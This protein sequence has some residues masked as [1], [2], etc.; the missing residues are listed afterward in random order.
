MQNSRILLPLRRIGRPSVVRYLVLAAGIAAMTALTIPGSRT[1]ATLAQTVLWGCLGVFAF[2]WARRAMAAPTTGR[3]IAYLTS[4]RGV[5]D[6]L[7]VLPAPLALACGVSPDVAW[8]FAA[9]WL[10]KLTPGAPGLGQLG[11]VLSQEARPLASV[12]ILFVIVLFF[13]AS[14]IHALEKDV[15]PDAFGSLPASLW[16][17][18]TTLTTTGY[19]D[20]VPRTD[21]GR[22]LAGLVMMCGLALFGLITGILATGFAGETRRHEFVQTW[23]LVAGVSFLQSL[24]PVGMAELARMLRRWDVPERT[25]VVRRGRHGDCM[26]FIASGEVEVEART[27]PVRLPAG[28]FF[29]EG[30]LLGNGVRNATVRTT[31]PSTLLILDLA[32]FRSFTAHHPDLARAVEIE[33]V[34]RQAAPAA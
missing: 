31:L 28:S 29:G 17:A 1:G 9:L 15:Q 5:I 14:A 25:V 16:W 13:A 2:E 32:D 18:V 6:A 4:A 34:R 33:A 19:G 26:Y 30:A 24:D 10:L 21:L 3:R 7:A 22:M 11:R 12:L 23:D 20:A 27:G 8:L